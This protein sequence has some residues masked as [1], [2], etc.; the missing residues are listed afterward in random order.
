MASSRGSFPFTTFTFGI[1]D[2][3]FERLV[4][5]TILKV[6]KGGQGR[7]GFTRPVVFP[8]WFS[9]MMKSDMG[10]GKRDE[11]LFDLAVEHAR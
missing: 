1:V 5:E 2:N 7:K 6:R 4:T 9:S 10:L 11:D 3:E 8:S